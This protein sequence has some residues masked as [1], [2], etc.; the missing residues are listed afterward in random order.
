MISVFIV[1]FGADRT[2]GGVVIGVANHPGNRNGG[3][4]WAVSG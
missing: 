3:S 2:V 4:V 1:K